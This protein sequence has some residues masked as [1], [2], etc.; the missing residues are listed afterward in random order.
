MI[1]R[2]GP[3][4]LT[5]AFTCVAKDPDGTIVEY[6]WGFGEGADASTTIGSTSHTY[7]EIGTFDAKVTVV[8][9]DGGE[10]T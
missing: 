9:S 3:P 5:L 6:R 2:S 4:D 7:T 1:G 10:T 8:A